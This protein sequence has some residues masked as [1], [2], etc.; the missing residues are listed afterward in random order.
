MIGAIGLR[1]A[2]A[3]GAQTQKSIVQLM[4]KLK[5]TV[6]KTRCIASG[7]C[8]ETAPAVFQLDADGKSE[9]ANEAGAPDGTIIAAARSC[10]VKAITVVNEETG[11]QM[12]PLPKK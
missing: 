8:V 1:N 12:F 3:C 4:A 7:D 5:I 9:V 10:P 11:E 2:V 6:N